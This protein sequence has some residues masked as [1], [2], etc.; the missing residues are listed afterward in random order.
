MVCEGFVTSADRLSEVDDASA[1]LDFR[2]VH[3]LP[4]PDMDET[5]TA[6]LQLFSENPGIKWC[7]LMEKIGSCKICAEVVALAAFPMH[8]CARP[9]V[10]DINTAAGAVYASSTPTI[11]P[12]SSPAR[13]SSSSSP[14]RASSS[15]LATPSVKEE[16]AH[17]NLYYQSSL[18][19]SPLPNRRVKTEQKVIEVIDLSHDE[20]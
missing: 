12:A 20:E 8:R 17:E 1:F 3:D 7:E 19:G 9:L 13:A 11:S 5:V 10:D 18:G 14:A 4:V 2:R 15:T 16:D 6:L